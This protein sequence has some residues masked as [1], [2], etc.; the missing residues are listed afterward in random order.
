MGIKPNVYDP[1]LLT[2]LPSPAP[3]TAFLVRVSGCFTFVQV[4]NLKIMLYSSSSSFLCHNPIFEQSS[5]TLS[6]RYTQTLTII[7]MSTSTRW[8][9]DT[10]IF[11][12]DYCNILLPVSLL[13]LFLLKTVGRYFQNVSQLML[14]PDSSSCNGAHF[15]ESKKQNLA[16]VFNYLSPH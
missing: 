14:L 2:L 6:L 4:P 8:V 10:F 3:C 15:I 11:H 1:E 13:L 7:Y 12:L 5:L 16:T 9:P